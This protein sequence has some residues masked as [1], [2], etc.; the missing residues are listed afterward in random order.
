[1]GVLDAPRPWIYGGDGRVLVLHWLWIHFCKRHCLLRSVEFAESHF[2]FW[3]WCIKFLSILRTLRRSDSFHRP[4]ILKSRDRLPLGVTDCLQRNGSLCY[5]ANLSID[6]QNLRADLLSHNDE[7]TST[8]NAPQECFSSITYRGE[9]RHP[10]F[11][12]SEDERL[13]IEA[14]NAVETELGTGEGSRERSSLERQSKCA[15]TNY[16]SASPV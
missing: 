14:E 1:M 12:L 3:I 16:L 6:W 11:L 8:F 13:T 5:L 15:N 2:G 7:V 9:L 10:A 4:A